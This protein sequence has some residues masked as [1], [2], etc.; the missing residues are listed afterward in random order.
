MARG[1]RKVSTETKRAA[2]EKAAVAKQQQ[3]AASALASLPEHPEKRMEIFAELRRFENDLKSF[4]EK[5]SHQKKRM[6]NVFG[7]LPKALRITGILESCKDGEYEAVLQQVQLFMKDRN[8]P[9]QLSLDL[10][11]GK[12]VSSDGKD[13][14]VFDQTATGGRV[15][16][17]DRGSGPG[18]AH[19]VGSAPASKAEPTPGIPL[20]EA[21][22]KLE[23]ASAGKFKTEEQIAAEKKAVEEQKARDA[24]EFEQQQGAQPEEGNVVQLSDRRRP[25]R[26]AMTPE[27]KAKAAEERKAAKQAAKKAAS[28]SK[29]SV[30][31]AADRAEANAQS[32]KPPAAA[33]NGNGSGHDEQS[34]GPMPASPPPPA[35]DFEEDEI[36]P[37]MGAAPEPAEPSGG[38]TLLA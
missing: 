35:P 7:M 12:G 13:A 36:P 33:P 2:Q 6:R 17:E 19:P 24:K 31:S 21:Q 3:L 28:P 9:V 11:P 14:P 4:Q 26:P 22:A 32:P 25:G 20:E 27:Q 8:R 18:Q 29:K 30:K 5:V 10:Q 37:V 15:A 38:Y 34:A 16:R 1:A 23:A